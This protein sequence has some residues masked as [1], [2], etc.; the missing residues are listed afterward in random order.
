MYM[1]GVCE[2]VITKLKMPKMSA[3]LYFT[4]LKMIGMTENWRIEDGM[5]VLYLWKGINKSEVSGL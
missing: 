3:N 4:K 2:I 5:C 1:K